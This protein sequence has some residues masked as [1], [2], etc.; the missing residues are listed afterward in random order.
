MRAPAG[1]AKRRGTAYIA[2]FERSINCK[3]M[4]RYWALLPLMLCVL[5]AAC[6]KDEA[7]DNTLA[8]YTFEGDSIPSIEQFLTDE[9]G[10]QLVATLS[11]SSGE[12]EDGEAAEEGD[13][14][15]D[16]GE[17]GEASD[18]TEDA[19]GGTAAAATEVQDYIAYDYQQFLEGQPGAI[20]QSYVAL[21]EGEE[22]SLQLEGG[23]DEPVSYDTRVGSVTLYRQ[24]VATDESGAPVQLSTA[25]AS[26]DEEG[27]DEGQDEEQEKEDENAE[28]AAPLAYSDYE[29]NTQRRFR[30]RVDWTPTSCLITLD[31]IDGQDFTTSLQEA[32]SFLSFSGAKVLMNS[33]TPEE[34][35]LPGESMAEYSLKPGPGFV[36][37]DGQA[38]LTVYVYGKNDVGTNSLMGT[39]F[40]SSDTSTLYHQL[41][42]GSDEVEKVHL[43]GDLPTDLPTEGDTAIKTG[44]D[45]TTAP[46]TTDGEGEEDTGDAEE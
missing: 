42:D 20:V 46:E 22:Y 5:L 6:G 2:I 19:E 32:G 27:G 26:T 34:I 40:I 44:T 15:E 17:D 13:E 41:A 29:H 30:V 35:G 12:E 43:S 8:Y 3:Q 18:E 4:K 25:S 14:A 11:P 24:A 1:P 28:D 38:C 39:Y 10:G 7:E 45:P 21:L 36:M 9:T 31:Q 23:E 37:V 16:G 33:V